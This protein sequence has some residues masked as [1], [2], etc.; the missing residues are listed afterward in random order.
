MK[1]ISNKFSKKVID[2]LK[3][4][5]GLDEKEIAKLA[6][7]STKFLSEILKGDKSFKQKQLDRIQQEHEVFLAMAPALIS[8]LVA[9]KT[10]T[11]RDFVA[12]K[13]KQAKRCSKKAQIRHYSLSVHWL[14]NIPTSP[15]LHPI[16]IKLYT[17]SDVILHRTLPVQDFSFLFFLFS[18]VT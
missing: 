4:E 9:A 13:T 10:K 16:A 3:D 5:K 12:E 11:G 14:R 15:D 17:K 7:T 2:F 6:G 8:E 1:Q 18:M